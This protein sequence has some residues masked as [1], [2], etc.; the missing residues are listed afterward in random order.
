MNALGRG[1]CAVRRGPEFTVDYHNL[2]G[3]AG[4]VAK[5]HREHDEHKQQHDDDYYSNNRFSHKILSL[6]KINWRA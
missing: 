2:V 3:R 5:R 1:I 6:N 4:L